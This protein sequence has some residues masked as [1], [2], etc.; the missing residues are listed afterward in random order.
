MFGEIEYEMIDEI[1][2]GDPKKPGTWLR[3]EKTEKGK[4]VI[5]SWSSLSKQWSVMYRYDVEENWKKWKKL[6]QRIQLKT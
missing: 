5:R 3:L 1:K 2:I 4:P 6:C